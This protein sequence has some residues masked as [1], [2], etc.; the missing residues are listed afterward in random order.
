GSGA[1]GGVTGGSGAGGGVTG[2]SGP[3]GGATGGSGAGAGGGV[4]AP[5]APARAASTMANVEFHT[6]AELSTGR[7]VVAGTR[8]QSSSTDPR[9]GLLLAFDGAQTTSS[10]VG[11]TANDQLFAIAANMD[12][13]CAGGFSRSF[14][15]TAANNQAFFALGSATAGPTLVRQYGQSDPALEVRAIIPNGTGWLWA[16]DH[17][18]ALLVATMNNSGSSSGAQAVTFPAG[19][20]VPRARSLEKRGT[21]LVVVGDINVSSPLMSM[22]VRGFVLVFEE[23]TATSYTFRWGLLA[24]G[25]NY[26]S[27]MDVTFD[28]AGNLLVAG[29]DGADGVLLRLDGMNGARLAEARVPTWQLRTIRNSNPPLVVGSSSTAARLLIG[30]WSTGTLSGVEFNGLEPTSLRSPVP[31]FQTDGGV[32]VVANLGASTVDVRLNAALQASCDGGVSGRNVA[33]ST[34]L[35]SGLTFS[36]LTPTITTV[37]LVTEFLSGGGLGSLAFTAGPVCIP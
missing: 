13:Y 3:G 36:Q 11:G 18:A 21:T 29:I 12:R 15:G 25:S 34:P 24:T 16:G 5:P 1:G 37:S 23:A 19:L 27:F 33:L 7:L 28:P 10:L 8:T 31:V 4:V 6:A 17:A 22:P 14:R 35:V 30:R 2:G 20:Q 26:T 32:R 9:D